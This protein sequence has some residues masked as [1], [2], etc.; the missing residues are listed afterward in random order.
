MYYSCYYK[1][2]IGDN[3]HANRQK[4]PAQAGEQRNIPGPSLIKISTL[5]C[6]TRKRIYTY[7]NAIF[8]TKK[9]SAGDFVDAYLTGKEM[10]LQY[11]IPLRSATGDN[12]SPE[13]FLISSQSY[14][15]KGNIGLAKQAVEDGLRENTDSYELSF[16]KCTFEA[17]TNRYQDALQVGYKNIF[18]T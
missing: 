15:E 1:K 17:A 9:Q 6:K 5:E 4:H 11:I 8:A 3:P 2:F 13:A 14:V 18:D 10:Y 7:G 12:S 16:N